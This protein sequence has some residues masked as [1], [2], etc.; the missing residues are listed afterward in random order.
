[1]PLKS[2]VSFKE[3]GFPQQSRF[4]RGAILFQL[5]HLGGKGLV[6]K[7]QFCGGF[8]QG[9]VVAPVVDFYRRP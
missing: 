7:Y 2:L 8:C 1:M 6:L 4:I 5:L 9:W 3:C